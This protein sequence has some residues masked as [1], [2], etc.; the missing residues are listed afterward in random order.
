MANY[1]D[2]FPRGTD[3]A[4]IASVQSVSLSGGGATRSET[5]TSVD[6]SKSIIIR[7]GHSEPTNNFEAS[8]VQR[9]A[10]FQNS[11]TLAD[12]GPDSGGSNIASD[13]MILEF[14][15]G[16][17]SLQTFVVTLSTSASATTNQAVMSVDLTKAV[18]IYTGVHATTGASGTVSARVKLTTS[19]NVACSRIGD[20]ITSECGFILVEFE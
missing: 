2:L 16:I 6:L 7:N 9:M 1:S 3:G 10:L 4:T 20:A 15:S 14:A 5:I 17:K 18:L 19:T 13:Y 12:K 8:Q 11:T